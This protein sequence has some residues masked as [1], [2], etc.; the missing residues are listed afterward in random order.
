[1]GVKYR[2]ERER[3]SMKNKIIRL[4]QENDAVEILKIYEPYIKDTPITFEYDIPSLD[5]F[6][7]RIKKIVM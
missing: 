7:N 2:S 5:E 4:I 6:T 1:M 3:C